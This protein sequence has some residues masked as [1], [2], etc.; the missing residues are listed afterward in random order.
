M[1]V[2][3]MFK[4][5]LTGLLHTNDVFRKYATDGNKETILAAKGCYVLMQFLALALGMWKIHKMGLLPT[6]RSDWLAWEGEG[7]QLEKAMYAF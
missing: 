4:T 1:M 6:T 3:M 5:P 7:T 2:F